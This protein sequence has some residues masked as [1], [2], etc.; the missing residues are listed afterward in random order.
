[1]NPACKAAMSGGAQFAFADGHVAFLSETI[2]L[3]TLWALT[4]RGPGVTPATEDPANTPYGGE[5]ISD[6]DY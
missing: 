3:A 2:R 5:V 1:M 4:T 6:S